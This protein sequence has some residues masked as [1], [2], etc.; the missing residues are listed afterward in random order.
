M[1]NAM[2]TT[3]QP[4]LLLFSMILFGGCSSDNSSWRVGDSWNVK[5]EAYSLPFNLSRGGYIP[6]EGRK[7]M[8][9]YTMKISIIGIEKID[10]SEFWKIDFTPDSTALFIKRESYQI[11]VGKSNGQISRVINPA[12]MIIGGSDI[13]DFDGHMFLIQAPSG[14]P[15]EIIPAMENKNH[16]KLADRNGMTVEYDANE[17]NGENVR[18]I[19]MN[20]RT[21]N[22]KIIQRTKLGYKWWN[23]YEKYLD[24]YIILKAE[25]L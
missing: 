20:F 19:K 16:A 14:F 7:P 15:L 9:I 5:V 22:Y 8:G 11:L 24:D 1:V 18:E 10:T 12:G 23:T 3:A 6:K 2:K 21:E 4:F 13:K 17:S 25:L